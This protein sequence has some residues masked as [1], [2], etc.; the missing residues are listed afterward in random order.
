[1]SLSLKQAT[2]LN[3]CLCMLCYNYTHI[4]LLLSSS[5]CWPD[6][7]VL[8]VFHQESQKYKVGDPK[9]FHYLNQSNF[10]KLSGVDESEEYLATRK[11]MDV[12]GISSDEQVLTYRSYL[13]RCTFK[14][15]PKAFPPTGRYIPCCCCN[16]PLR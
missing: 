1:M 2:A 16:S 11:A 15:L 6:V 7:L 4:H 3:L 5:P 12:V 10:Y 14:I 8:H 13:S 9:T